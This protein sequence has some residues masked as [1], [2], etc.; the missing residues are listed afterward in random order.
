[1]RNMFYTALILISITQFSSI[2]HLA[3]ERK[4]TNKPVPI[5][6]D[7]IRILNNA[8]T[9]LDADRKTLISRL[10]ELGQTSKVKEALLDTVSHASVALRKTQSAFEAAAP[11][12]QVL[13]ASG[14][15]FGDISPRY[16]SAAGR[17]RDAQVNEYPSARANVLGLLDHNYRAY[18]VV[19]TKG[20]LTFDLDVKSVPAGAAVSYKRQGSNY[21]NAQ[22][23]NTTIPSL[24][25]AIWI[26]RA[27]LD[28][29][30]EQEKEHDPF[31]ERN[32]VV[33]FDL[34]K[35]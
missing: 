23:T 2:A 13:E 16:E 34:K 8:A 22:Q 24:V 15:F 25:Y 29:Y 20:S 1:M 10:S 17:L 5:N 31:R 4:L 19:A 11:S 33:V 6:R 27:Q 35:K 32:H 7:Q 3:Q 28:G 9:A 12:A 26:V 14:I 18:V 30:E 21:R